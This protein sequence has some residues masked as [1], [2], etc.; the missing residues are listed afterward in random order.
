MTTD[1][2]VIGAE[3]VEATAAAVLRCPAVARLHSGRFNAITSYL[4]GRRVVGIALT[5][6]E[7]T[8]GVVGRYPGTVAQIAAQVREA[9]AAVVPGVA[10]TVAVEDID[11][12]PVD[13]SEG[14]LQEVAVDRDRMRKE[15]LR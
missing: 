5:P 12:A 3:T 7:V 11:I 8:V 13:P 9:V 2:D 10:V 4:P 15:G 6:S 14:D 1:S